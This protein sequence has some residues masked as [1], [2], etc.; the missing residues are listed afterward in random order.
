MTIKEEVKN[1]AKS[2]REMSTAKPME[3]D[4]IYG[5]VEMDWDDGNED[6]EE[7]EI[8]YIGRLGEKGKGKGKGLCFACGQPGHRANECWSR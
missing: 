8:D 7:A 2:R 1:I 4:T 3:V 5:K 6:E